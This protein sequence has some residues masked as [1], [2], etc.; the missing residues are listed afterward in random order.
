MPARAMIVVPISELSVGSSSTIAGA[1][2][3]PI[4]D[5]RCITRRVRPAVLAAGVTGCAKEF[6]ATMA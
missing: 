6:R 1:V 2:L 3:E 4:L 5:I